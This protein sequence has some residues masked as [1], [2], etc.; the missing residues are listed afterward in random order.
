MIS[1]NPT[2]IVCTL[3]PSSETELVLE[4][5]VRAGMDVARLNFSHGSHDDHAR[6]FELIR[7][8]ADRLGTHV[9]VVADL[10]G[11]KIRTGELVGGK[12]VELAAGARVC[13]TTVP[14]LGT[15]E[16]L[17]TTYQ[18]L[19]SDVSPG[20]K[21]L[22]DDGLLELLVESVGPTDIQ[23]RVVT[24][25]WLG[26]HKGINLPGCEVS[27]P[28]L[29]D[30]DKADVSFALALGIDYLALSFVR[31]P[32]DISE[33]RAL[34]QAEGHQVPIITKLEKPQALQRL[35]EIVHMSDAVMVARGDLGVELPPEEV[36]VW[37]KRII[38]ECARAGIPVITATQMLESMRESP[39]PTRAEASDVANAIFDGTD[40]VMLSAE[41]AVGQYPVEAVAMMRRIACVAEGE[42]RRWRHR[43]WLPAATDEEELSVA[44]AV[45]RAATRVAEEVR[46][47]AIVAFTESGSTARS[48]SKRRPR[49]PIVACTPSAA[50]ARRCSLY[51][52]VRSVVV[53]NVSATDEMI[54]TTTREVKRLELVK[55][56]DRIVLTAGVP[57]GRPGTTNTMRVETIH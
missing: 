31:K 44:D 32:E 45:S 36:P 4:R 30:K 38:A 18:A 6:V 21:L 26:E 19:P 37:Q 43:E 5:M 10:Q 52:G 55:P 46:A 35:H 54:E 47:Q 49:V 56:G 2:K 25:G 3:G 34:C 8:V 20:A 17:S 57:M 27:A 15:A 7:K 9:G 48:A 39:R 12:P 41:T 29:T 53:G 13:L 14:C 16:C 23:C 24:G 28:S 22:L 51:W 40:A 42:Q 33:L 1:Y 11:P 50:T